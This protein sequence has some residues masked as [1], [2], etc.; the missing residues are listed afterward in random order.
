[1]KSK[2]VIVVGAHPDDIEI[3]CGGT[4]SYLKEKN[5][6]VHCVF[7]TD[8]EKGG[9]PE[10]RRNESIKACELLR[11]DKVFF[12]EFKD[13][14][15]GSSRNLIRY[16]EKFV[17]EHN[18]EI[19]LIPT[20]FDTHQDHRKLYRVSLSA[21]REVPIVLSYESP[22]TISGFTPNLFFDIG[23]FMNLKR[24]AIELHETQ[25]ER[26][27]L[28]WESMI[29]LSSYRGTQSGCKHAE[30]FSVER[31]LVNNLLDFD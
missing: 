10:I 19:A 4:V 6:I 28:E 7:L 13:T 20:T 8:G 25:K 24:K 9:P 3:S 27:Y 21:F 26:S 23:N 5:Y 16:L 1:M 12:G 17:K 15:L 30:A 18:Y 11:L 29:N 14:D 2:K 22:S 31:I